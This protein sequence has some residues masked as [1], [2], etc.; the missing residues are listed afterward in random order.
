[1]KT[2]IEIPDMQSSHCQIRV[3][4]ALKRVT[5]VT[6]NGITAGSADVTLDKA[7]TLAEATKAIVAAGYTVGGTSTESKTSDDTLTF[8]TNINCGGCVAKVTP[9]LSNVS[10]IESWNVDTTNK[11]K[12]LSVKSNGITADQVI[13]TVKKAGFRI[14]PVGQ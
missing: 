1:M 10:G 11:D 9:A 8:K 14:E 3:H 5:G 2:K 13:E 4:E 12:I 7:E 6:L